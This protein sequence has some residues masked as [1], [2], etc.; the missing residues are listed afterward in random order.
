MDN[1]RWHKDGDEKTMSTRITPDTNL[2]EE[3]AYA[4]EKMLQLLSSSEM[5]RVLIQLSI[6]KTRTTD[7]FHFLPNINSRTLSQRLRAL[8]RNGLVVRQSYA[9][10]PPRVE[11]SLTP[12]GWET[13]DLLKSFKE[14]AKKFKVG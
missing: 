5:V 4:I 8:Q 10:S 12:I 13:I 2:K 3:D 11:Y 9:E 7:F 1:Y 6:A 14:V